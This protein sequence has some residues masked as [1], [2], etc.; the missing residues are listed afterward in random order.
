MDL[1]QVP[2]RSSAFGLPIRRVLFGVLVCATIAGLLLLAG[3]T[4]S[5]GGI[6]ALDTAILVLFAIT[7]PWT[8]IGFWNAL[9]GFLVMR[10]SH[11]PV[12]VVF[13]AAARARND[14]PIT[15]RC[16]VLVCIRNESPQHVLRNLAPLLSGLAADPA[17]R[18][19]HF[20]ILSDTNDPEIALEEENAFASLAATWR[21][22]IAITYRRRLDNAG[23]KAGNIRDFCE[24]WGGDHD[25]AITLDA[26]S[27]MPAS[28][29]LRLVRLM[30]TEPSLGIV[31]ALVVGL[32]AT[33]AFTRIFQFGMRFGM[34][35]YTIGSAWW[36]G[37][38]GPYWGHNA[39]L[40][41]APFAKDCQLPLL[42][43]GKHVLSH[44][45]VEAV[46]MRR[47]GYEV[48][49][50]P[51]EDL[52]WEENPPTLVEFIRRDLR[53]CQ[54]NMQYWRFLITPGLRLVSRCQL[55]IA[56][57][58]FLGSPAWV[59][60]MVLGT[61]LALR[62]PG[63]NIDPHYGWALLG[64]VLFMWFAPKIATVIDVMLRPPLRH[65]YGGT[66][67]LLGSVLTET[68]FFILLSPIQWVSHTIQLTKLMLGA[69]VGWSAQARH[70]H[71]V[72]LAQAIV[73]FWPHTLIG[74]GCIG[75]LA[76]NKPAAI[77]VMLLIAGGP[78]LAIPLAVLSAI[79]SV[80]RAL[81]DCGLCCLPEERAPPE[82]LR[83][84]NV[85]ALAVRTH[86]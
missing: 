7:L 30:Q 85:P 9:N 50:L 59:G 76:L 64:V 62:A 58:M 60:L 25:V 34:R 3:L 73:R 22:R 29:A 39:I 66:L 43:N 33:S 46:L 68:I 70:A 17:A 84:M 4:L 63:T 12:A 26:D 28:A 44:D 48:R 42:P 55:A 16:A 54:G 13:P 5:M 47:A 27:L 36:Q 53:W 45:Q 69:H 80:G 56:I 10:F 23:F 74:L 79:P 21:E 11:D 8:V 71:S 72:P 86:A 40:R 41:L 31:Q 38:C 78:L 24:R 19:F 52:G 6:D 35:S 77:P 49:V 20:Y 75:T 2:I 37:D 61:I 51:E 14:Q 81:I 57:L 18:Q 82:I 1:P 15:L 32:P 65:A 67:R 83:D